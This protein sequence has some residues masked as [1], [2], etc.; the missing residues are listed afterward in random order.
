MGIDEAWVKAELER[1]EAETEVR[2]AA[3][4]TAAT[5]QGKEPFDLAALEALYDTET[6]LGYLPPEE[7]RRIRWE[8]RYYLDHPDVMTL[9]AFAARLEAGDPYR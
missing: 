4:V 2:L 6:D 5:Q 7:T 3:A 1:R 9:R 8:R